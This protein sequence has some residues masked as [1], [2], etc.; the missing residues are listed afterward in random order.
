MTHLDY[1]ASDRS[2]IDWA[3]EQLARLK[4]A[5]SRISIISHKDGAETSLLH[6]KHLARFL[7]GGLLAGGVLATVAM[8][9]IPDWLVAEAGTVVLFLVAALIVG[10]VTWESLLYGI[11]KEVELETTLMN[12]CGGGNDV[13]SIDVADEDVTQVIYAL[14]QCDELK[15]IK[16]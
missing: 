11:Q 12:A 13:L 6:A 8:F 10:F 7:I 16:T 5:K 9:V 4:V 1:I 2:S 14:A 3:Q 15:L